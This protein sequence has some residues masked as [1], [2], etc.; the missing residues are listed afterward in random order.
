MK[1]QPI[2]TAPDDRIHIRGVWVF[3][4]NLYGKKVPSYFDINV[5]YIDGAGDFVSADDGDFG[6]SADAYDWWC[7]IPMPLPEPPK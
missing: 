6:W 4:I 1:W 7:E 5:G 2:E 3:T